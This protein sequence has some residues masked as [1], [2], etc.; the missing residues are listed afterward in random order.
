MGSNPFYISRLRIPDNDLKGLEWFGT[1]WTEHK[2]CRV[3]S[4]PG[5]AMKPWWPV[6]FTYTGRITCLLDGLYGSCLQTP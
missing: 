3:S 6:R 1:A 5:Q 2:T 4:T